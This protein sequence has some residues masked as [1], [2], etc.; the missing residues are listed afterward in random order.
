M[1]KRFSPRA[2]AILEA[3]FVT[4]IWST[5]WVLIKVGLRDVPA[6]TFAGLRYGLA[7]IC[8]L[9]IV[10]A[11]PSQRA[12]L[13]SLSRASW[14]RLILLGFLFFGV[15]QATV[16][17][18]LVSLPAFTVSLLLNLTTIVVAVLGI[19]WLKERLSGL[20]WLGIAVS[21]GA[22]LLYFYPIRL[23]EG[24]A[25]ALAVVCVGV[26]S[27]SASSVLNR[28]INR[29]GDLPPLVVSVVSL[30]A[31]AL[32][33]M[34]VGFSLQ[35]VPPLQL[36]DWAVIS[37]LAV[38]NTALGFTLWNHTLRT[39]AAVESSIIN[40]TM[41][42][43]IAILAWI[44]LG[45]RITLQQA[46]GMILAGLGAVIVQVRGSREAAEALAETPRL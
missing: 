7:F 21:V 9:P 43:Q 35:G 26:L 34:G 1:S 8:V 20:Q 32:V 29:G 6:L 11:D 22:V 14:M 25:I 15:T 18:G 31:G 4:V 13:R 12:S 27:N 19:A 41:I 3:I 5:S 40:G 2:A 30:G 39:L 42:I 38:I 45:E 37:W 36:K 46:V 33:L 23:P 17:I 16:Y 10:A 44:F 28:R 24:Q